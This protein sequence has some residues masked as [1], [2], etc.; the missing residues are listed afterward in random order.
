MQSRYL[1]LALAVCFLAM[2]SLISAEAEG[3]GSCG[4]A[5]YG[6]PVY[7]APPSTVYYAPT[8]FYA[9]PMYQQPYSS[10][11]AYGQFRSAPPSTVYYAPTSYYSA[12]M[13]QQ[14]YSSTPMYPRSA[15]RSTAYYAPSYYSAPTCQQPYSSAPAYGQSRSAPPS[16]V[17]PTTAANVVMYDNNF[18]PKTINVQPGTTVRWTNNGTHNHTVTAK[19]GSWDS[20]D[21]RPGATYSAT[22]QQPGT[23]YYYCRHHDGMQGTIVVGRGAANGYANPRSS[24]Y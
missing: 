21:I 23:Y 8:S 20:G 15:P 12:P 7:Y 24:G 18:Q 13:Y 11:P 4:G 3:D 19:N 16:R 5:F 9:G 6:G 10:A 2:L 22:F 1:S 17:Q 14:P